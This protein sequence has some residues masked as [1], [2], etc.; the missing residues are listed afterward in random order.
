MAR[1][2]KNETTTDNDVPVTTKLSTYLHGSLRILAAVNGKSVSEQLRDIVAAAVS[3]ADVSV[4]V[5]GKPVALATLANGNGGS[6]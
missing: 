1:T 2:A 6:E 3:A 5:G 4:T